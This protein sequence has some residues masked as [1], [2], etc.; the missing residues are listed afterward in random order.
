MAEQLL[1]MGDVLYAGLGM[2]GRG[3]YVMAFFFFFFF[4]G[5]SVGCVAADEH[6]G[7]FGLTM[8]WESFD[9]SWQEY[10]DFALGDLLHGENFKG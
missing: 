1:V 7:V 10:R 3:G 8:D 2:T 9:C 6:L 4:P 5:P